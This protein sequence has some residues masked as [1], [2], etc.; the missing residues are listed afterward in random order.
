[1]MNTYT[2]DIYDQFIWFAENGY[3]RNLI[4]KSIDKYNARDYIQVTI[5]KP[6]KHGSWLMSRGIQTINA[7]K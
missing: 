2:R 5:V 7:N 6:D 3:I 1:M 4:Q